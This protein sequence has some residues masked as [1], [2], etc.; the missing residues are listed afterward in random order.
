VPESLLLNKLEEARF[1]PSRTM[2][3]LQCIAIIGAK[4]NPLY[5]SETT[6]TSSNN[7][8]P[9]E[10]ETDC[11]GFNDP[12]WK[13]NNRSCKLSIRHEVRIKGFL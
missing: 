7:E 13:E 8:T 1:D 10:E 4:N 11:F 2:V 6:T 9:A 12:E 5:L 3:S